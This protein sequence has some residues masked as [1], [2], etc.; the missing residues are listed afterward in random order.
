MNKQSIKKLSLFLTGLEQR[1]AENRDYLKKPLLFLSQEPGNF[2]QKY[3]LREIK[4]N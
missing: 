1:I 2:L 3:G 4:L